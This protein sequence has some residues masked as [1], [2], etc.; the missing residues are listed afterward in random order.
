[1]KISFASGRIVWLVCWGPGYEYLYSQSGILDGQWHNITCRR[2]GQTLSVLTDGIVRDTKTHP[3][4]ANTLFGP[5]WGP[6]ALGQVYTGVESWPF[7][8]SDFRV[9]KRALSDNEIAVL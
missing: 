5:S 1:M 3:D 7:A 6:K 4:Y 2:K 8:M 9:Y